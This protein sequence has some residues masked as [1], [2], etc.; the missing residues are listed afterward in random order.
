MATIHDIP[1]EVGTY[2][3]FFM[4]QRFNLID[5]FRFSQKS[6]NTFHQQIDADRPVLTLIGNIFG[7]QHLV[8]IPTAHLILTT[9]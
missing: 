8:L 6:S 2:F 1:C 7:I 9:A 4:C 5:P 3:I